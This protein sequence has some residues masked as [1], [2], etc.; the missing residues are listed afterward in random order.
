MRPVSLSL[1]KC[2]TTPVSKARAGK[3]VSILTVQQPAPFSSKGRALCATRNYRPIRCKLEAVLFAPP[4]VACRFDPVL[5]SSAQAIPPSADR[6]R[7]WALLIANLLGETP[8][9]RTVCT[10]RT[11]PSR[12]A[13]AHRSLPT[14]TDISVCAKI[15]HAVVVGGD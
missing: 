1:A 5:I 14:R 15:G 12:F 4:F 8:N 11:A 6:S 9:W 7:D 3:V 13:C 10:V 2:L